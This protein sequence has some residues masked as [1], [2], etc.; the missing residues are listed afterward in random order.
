MCSVLGVSRSAYYAYINEQSYVLK[1]EKAQI[2]EAVKRVFDKHRRHYGWRR[3]Q[4]KLADEGL[5]VGRHQ[6]CNRM[7]EQNLVAI[8]AKSFVPK[9]TQSSAY[10]TDDH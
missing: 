4:A 9:T 8:Q 5:L 10:P 1:G 6:I 7:K 2:K 3:I